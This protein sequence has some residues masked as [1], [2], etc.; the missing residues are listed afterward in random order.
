MTPEAWWSGMWSD[1]TFDQ[2]IHLLKSPFKA[3]KIYISVK[4]YTFSTIFLFAPTGARRLDS[5]VHG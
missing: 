2:E 1:Y 3:H 5:S 4:N